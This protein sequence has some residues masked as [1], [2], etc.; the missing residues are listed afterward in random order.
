MARFK[1]L[2][3][4]AEAAARVCFTRVVIASSCASC[5]RTQSRRINIFRTSFYS[6]FFFLSADALNF[7]SLLLF[8]FSFSFLLC[9]TAVSMKR[10]GDKNKSLIKSAPL[11]LITRVSIFHCRV[12]LCPFRSIAIPR[13]FARYNFV[14]RWLLIHGN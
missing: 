6:S 14:S 9:N 8:S 11:F 10:R 13:P 2:I 4:R 3:S 1:I 12:K 5:S 7:Y